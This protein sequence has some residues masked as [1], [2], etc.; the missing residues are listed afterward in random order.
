[1]RQRVR[2]LLSSAASA[3][4]CLLCLPGQALAWDYTPTV[5]SNLASVYGYLA[6]QSITLERAA[7]QYPSMRPE[8]E[9][10]R[11]EFDRQFPGALDAVT[12]L[13]QGIPLPAADRARLA[14]KV[15]EMDRDSIQSALANQQ[16]VRDFLDRVRG[17]AR[18]EMEPDSL[19]LLLAAVYDEEP[20]A[21]LKTPMA[22]VLHTKGTPAAKDADVAL[23]MPLSWERNAAREKL[24][25]AA[26]IFAFNSQGGSG[27]STI[28]LLTRPLP[29]AAAGGAA[30]S[31]AAGAAGEAS[32]AAA[33][34]ASKA[35][36]A[37]AERLANAL[38]IATG[39]TPKV[40][41]QG[42]T[43]LKQRSMTW[44][45]FSVANEGASGRTVQYGR[46]WLLPLRE[47]N[48]TMMLV[49]RT[50]AVPEAT[51]EA[52]RKRLTP[53]WEAVAASITVAPPARSHP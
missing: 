28:D 7:E 16:A 37:E 22:R 34:T 6:S 5:I 50:G 9:R 44:V 53:L 42:T 23:R 49:C 26:I 25:D 4:A 46:L 3:L 12:R 1:M 17:T 51:A 38:R 8:I 35:A 43:R 14:T 19:Q 30:D 40:L 18:G 27:L 45:S 21:E 47:Y 20:A 31:P 41:A 32:R 29:Q 52:E 36:A 33:V 48:Q 11:A 24:K 15:L 13:F 2:V 10:T 39:A